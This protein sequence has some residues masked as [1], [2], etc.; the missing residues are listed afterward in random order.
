M[1]QKEA[2]DIL[3]TGAN[4]FLTG[5]PGAGKTHT[6][7]TFVTYLRSAGL[8]PAI[9]ASTGIAATH[10]GGMTIHSWSGIGIKKFLSEYDLEEIVDKER[11]AK[12]VRDTKTLIIDEVSM[13]DGRT[14]TMVD[15]VCRAIKNSNRPFGGLQIILVGDFF[16]LP[17]ITH[18]G[19]K[20]EFAFQ[21]K[22]WRELNPIVCYL[23]EQH[24]Q[25]D[26]DLSEILS[27]LRSGNITSKHKD[28]LL[29]RCVLPDANV[30]ANISKLFP[31]NADVDRINSTELGKL[32]GNEKVFTMKG[33]GNPLL[34]DQLKRGCLSPERLALKL[35]ARVM[36]TKNSFDGKFVNGTTGEVIGFST[37]SGYPIVRIRDGRTIHTEPLEWGIE[38]DGRLLAKV[39]QVPLRLAWAITVHKSQG[40]SLDAAFVDLSGAFEY[41][42]GYVAL[43]RVR[44]M[45]G[46]YLGGLND[47]A[48]EVHS[49]VSAADGKFQTASMEARAAF[50]TFAPEVL[51]KMQLDF[52][53]AC[54][55]KLGVGP[56]PKRKKREKGG[57]LEETLKLLREGKNIKMIAVMR[58]LTAGTVIGHL[59]QLQAAE[60]CTA[61]EFGH[62]IHG[63]ESEITAINETFVKLKTDKLAPVYEHFRG[64]HSYDLIRLARLF[65]ISD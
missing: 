36:F 32:S 15:Q 50:S 8:E 27:A 34:I 55:G 54:G 1:T 22:V 16:Q 57:T 21:S 61:T 13:L 51:Q 2:L 53:T 41:G 7:N 19:D 49:D 9:T 17:P 60:K 4:V 29:S 23:S 63:A 25:D 48:L 56:K 3:K 5:E 14:L 64:K 35:G 62:L 28:C 59:E 47:R 37:E 44:T 18:D 38:A 26:I 45:Q 20:A 24:R 12:R 65:S 10:I 6:I 58:G 43:S 33:T 40:I 31:H 42:Q 11:V 46:L 30:H 52:V 39:T